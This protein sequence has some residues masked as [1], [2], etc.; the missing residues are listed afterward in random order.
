MLICFL[1]FG[2]KRETCKKKIDAKGQISMNKMLVIQY[3]VSHYWTQ[4]HFFEKA[5]NDDKQSNYS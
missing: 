1:N 4:E 3:F 5:F 2:S